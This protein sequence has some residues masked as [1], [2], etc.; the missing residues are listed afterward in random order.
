MVTT[1][2]ERVFRS[3]GQQRS[4]SLYKVDRATLQRLAEQAA[5]SPT[6]P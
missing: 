2:F 6:T 4:V 5:P 3:P 1:H